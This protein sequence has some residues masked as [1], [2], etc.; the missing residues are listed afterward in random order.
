MNMFKVRCKLCAFINTTVN[1]HRL[2]THRHVF[3]FIIHKIAVDAQEKK[4][5]KNFY[6]I[7]LRSKSM[8]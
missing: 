5:K 2:H 3:N 8:I 1:I 4:C 6:D 7:D